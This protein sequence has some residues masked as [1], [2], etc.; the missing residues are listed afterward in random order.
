MTGLLKPWFKQ[1]EA[2]L[3][4]LAV[5]ETASRVGKDFIVPKSC[6]I[7]SRYYNNN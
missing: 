2:L 1:A 7:V 6:H 5:R 3:W 4:L